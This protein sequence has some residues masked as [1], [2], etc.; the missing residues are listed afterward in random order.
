M[1]QVV[2]RLSYTVCKYC[3]ERKQSFKGKAARSCSIQRAA[4]WMDDRGE[5][6]LQRLHFYAD[7]DTSL[8]LVGIHHSAI[9][10]ITHFHTATPT[11]D[12]T[13]QRPLAAIR[14]STG[15]AQGGGGRWVM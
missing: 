8:L 14:R 11:H 1:S 7:T 3:D 10:Y 2:A 5:Y 9:L 4:P 6:L 13:R 15:I 12:H